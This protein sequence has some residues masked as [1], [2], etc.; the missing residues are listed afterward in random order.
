[1]FRGSLP[2]AAINMFGNIIKD[3]NCE[4]IYVGCSGNFTLERAINTFYEGRIHGNDVTIYSSSLGRL[5]AGDD[6]LMEFKEGLDDRLAFIRDQYFNDDMDKIAS[7]M[8]MTDILPYFLVSEEKDNTYAKRMRNAYTEQYPVMHS[9]TKA[10]LEVMKLKLSSFFAGDVCMFIND[11]PLDQGVACYP[12]FFS[13]DYEKMFKV[14]SDAM[15]W[16]EPSY[17]MIDKE[18]IYELFRK[19][20]THKYFLFAV[21]ERLDEFEFCLT[22]ITTT[23][24]R[25][26]PVYIYSNSENKK[27]IIPNQKIKM[28][29][30]DR[31]SEEDD[32]DENDDIKLIK[33]KS[34]EFHALRSQYMNANI[35][36]GQETM[37]IGIMVRNLLIGVYA[38]S[39]S[40]MLTGDSLSKYIETPMI[41]LLSDFPV[42]STKYKR[43]AKLVLYSALSKESKLIAERL[44]KRRVRS[45]STTAFSKNQASMK[46]RGILELFVKQKMDEEKVK[47]EGDISDKYYN[48]GYKLCYGALMGGWTLREGLKIWKNK[49]G[50]IKKVGEDIEN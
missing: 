40:P 24:N 25:A 14:V 29:M 37:A 35:K 22:G 45:L 11:I 34:E 33:L 13:G 17:D 20:T 16:E 4:D 50:V 2:S 41:Y 21:N 47:D 31:I 27:I 8:I 38:F 36:P 1:M 15:I 44:T 5:L 28:L 42:N 43:L 7:I 19:M 32:I 23:T 6:L 46:Y 49:H 26:V 30:I 10:K 9:K 12:P 3:W 39:T 48:S 18:K